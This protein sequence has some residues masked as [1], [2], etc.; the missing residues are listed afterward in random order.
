MRHGRVGLIGLVMLL[1]GACGASERGHLADPPAEETARMS[2][3]QAL[4]RVMD[5]LG[6]LPEV[7]AL[8]ARIEAAGARFVVMLEGD[9]DPAVDRPRVWQIYVGESHPD[10]LV[11]LWAF[12]VDAVTGALTV[13]DPVTLEDLSFE[14]WREQLAASPP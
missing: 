6:A 8:R 2:G 9:D 4:D 10:H 14:R 3:D 13:T 11:R 12:N 5:A 1:G 7:T